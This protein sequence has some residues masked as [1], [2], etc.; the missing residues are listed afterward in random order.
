MAT[1][2]KYHQTIRIQWFALQLSSVVN[3]H[4]YLINIFTSE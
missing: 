2:D 3:Q 1:Y 4:M